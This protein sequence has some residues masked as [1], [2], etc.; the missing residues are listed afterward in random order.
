MTRPPGPPADPDGVGPNDVDP[1]DTDPGLFRERTELAWHR[2]GIAFAAL[3]GAVIKTA[4]VVGLLI[5]ASS[6]PI[7]VLART[8]RRGPRA[9]GPEL[10]RSLLLISIAVTALSLVALVLA[11][12]AA[13]HPLSP[14]CQPTMRDLLRDP[15]AAPVP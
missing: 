2:T 1:E 6:V 13:D 5:L 3:G 12:F 14:S 4:P 11:F 8:S 9:D 15:Q 7:F 10:R